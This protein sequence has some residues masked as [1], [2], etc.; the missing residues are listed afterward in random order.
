MRAKTIRLIVRAMGAVAAAVGGRWLRRA[1]RTRRQ[2][3]AAQQAISQPKGEMFSVMAAPPP[4]SATAVE[5]Q[6]SRHR[7]MPFRVAEVMGQSTL[8]AETAYA[9]K[10]NNVM[11]TVRG[12]VLKSL[13]TDTMGARH[14][15]FVVKL[16][17]GQSVLIIHNIDDAPRVPVRSGDE[18]EVRGR[19]IW[20]EQGGE[21][22]WTHHD[23]NGQLMG[24]YIELARTGQ[25]YE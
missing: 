12:V 7:T 19:Y 17:S 11:L 18:V 1:Q 6:A 25:R 24:G 4:D 5:E 16:P 15:K 14:Q 3:T 21:M 20:N 23:P 22:H 2:Q 9:H 10:Y 8:T 13:R